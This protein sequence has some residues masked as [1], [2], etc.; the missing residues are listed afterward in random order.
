MSEIS[1]YNRASIS[2]IIYHS[3][4]YKRVSVRNSYT[5]K[6]SDNK[7]ID[8]FG[9]ILWFA[10]EKT[11]NNFSENAACL[12]EKFSEVNVNMF[13]I[14]ETDDSD[15]PQDNFL[16]VKLNH[17]HICKN[18]KEVELVKPSQILSLCLNIRIDDLLF[19]CEEPNEEERNL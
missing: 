11:E 7:N 19:I 13:H 14:G 8:C 12:I 1:F 3:E 5:V 18:R 4:D 15:A 10:K 17:V 9:Q 6:Y 2:G 16:G